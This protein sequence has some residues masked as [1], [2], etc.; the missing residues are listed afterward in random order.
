MKKIGLFSLL[1]AFMVVLAAC[2]SSD[3]DEGN[4]SGGDGDGKVYKVGIDTTYPPFEFQEGDEYKGIDVDLIRAIAKDQGFEIELEPMDFSGIIPAMQAGELDIAIA[5]M[6]ITDDRKK[7]VDFSDPY[8]EAGLSLVVA[9]GNSDITSLEDL[10]GKKVAVKKGTTGAAF[11]EEN[12][13]KYGY[14]IVQ[15]N[16]ST[17][18]F[19]E[20]ANGTADALIE[21]YPVISYAIAQSDLKLQVVG[22]RLNGDNYGI[23]VLK[24][25]NDELLKKINDGLAALKE[26]GKY[27]EILSTYLGE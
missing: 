21:D 3:S 14:E 13:D 16:D 24:G 23:A 17:S 18:M 26:S 11:A 7:V 8:F 27:D 20:V 6:S 4:A 1:F 22:D 10:K 2:G 5:G 19:Q 15:V 25:E 12:K 9:E